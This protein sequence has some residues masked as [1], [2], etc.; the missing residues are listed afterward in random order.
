MIKFLLVGVSAV[1]GIRHHR[2]WTRSF[3]EKASKSADENISSVMV[4]KS[5]FSVRRSVCTNVSAATKDV[6]PSETWSCSEPMTPGD[7]S[8]V[9]YRSNTTVLDFSSSGSLQLSLGRMHTP[10]NVLVSY[11]DCNSASLLPDLD[12]MAS[13]FAIL[14]LDKNTAEDS[15]KLNSQSVPG[16]ARVDVQTAVYIFDLATFNDN[17]LSLS[18]AGDFLR[19]SDAPTSV[20]SPGT[21]YNPQIV[22]VP[23]AM[24]ELDKWF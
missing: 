24:V 20:C 8:E 3:G 1:A 7:F 16:S 4:C 18:L 15:L 21:M 5:S 13:Y 11:S 2:G 14:I 22:R 10:R 9:L 23:H 12:D 17:T 19:C 6:V